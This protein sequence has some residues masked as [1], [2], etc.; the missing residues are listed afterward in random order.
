MNVVFVFF[1]KCIYSFFFIKYTR[2]DVIV[3]F[4][5]KEFYKYEG[6]ENFKKSLSHLICILKKTVYYIC[7][8]RKY[9]KQW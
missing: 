3:F 1:L 9:R 4:C 6:G 2:K 7:K 8:P 5:S